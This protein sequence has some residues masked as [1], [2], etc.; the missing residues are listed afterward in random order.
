MLTSCDVVIMDSKEIPVNLIRG[1]YGGPAGIPHNI[2]MYHSL[3]SPYIG[4]LLNG[5]HMNND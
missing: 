2:S 1:P 3:Y 5:T 4:T